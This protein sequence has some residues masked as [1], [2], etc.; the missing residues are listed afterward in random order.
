[1][2]SKEPTHNSAHKNIQ[3]TPVLPLFS[4]RKPI[5]TRKLGNSISVR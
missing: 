3:Q 2:T 4:D 1:M 5:E